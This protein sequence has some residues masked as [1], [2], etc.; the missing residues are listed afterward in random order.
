MPMPLL[1]ALP[2]L[3]Y[4]LEL[5]DSQFTLGLVSR[6]EEVLPVRFDGFLEVFILCPRLLLL[7]YHA[8]Q[9]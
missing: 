2:A 3:S 6:L 9:Y 5:F 1:A 4:Q 7:R 8:D